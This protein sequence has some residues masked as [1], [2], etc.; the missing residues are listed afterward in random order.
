MRD[1]DRVL[2]LGVRGVEEGDL[3]QDGSCS[4]KPRRKRSLVMRLARLTDLLMQLSVAWPGLALPGSG[5]LPGLIPISTDRARI[6]V[7][8]GHHWRTT[9]VL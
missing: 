6:W 2:Q 3:Q 4:S 7:V 8:E 5:S 1:W 9:P